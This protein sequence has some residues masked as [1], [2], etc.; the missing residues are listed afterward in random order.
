MTSRSSE[1]NELVIPPSFREHV[2]S[3]LGERRAW[4]VLGLAEWMVVENPEGLLPVTGDSTLRRYSF[5]VPSTSGDPTPW[6]IEL[7]RN[8]ETG[9]RF[10]PTRIYPDE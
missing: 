7:E 10:T 6:V 4:L 9:M 8:D 3:L 1:D 2:I 5:S